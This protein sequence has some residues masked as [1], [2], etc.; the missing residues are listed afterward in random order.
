M[1]LELRI[2]QEADGSFK[3]WLVGTGDD[4]RK[5]HAMCPG[6]PTARAAVERAVRLFAVNSPKFGI[7][8]TVLIPSQCDTESLTL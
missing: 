3:C 8:A 6:H 7:G 5:T 1:N 4:G 2:E